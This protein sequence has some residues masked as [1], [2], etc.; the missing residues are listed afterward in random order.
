M[1][2]SPGQQWKRPPVPFVHGSSSLPQHRLTPLESGRQEV[3]P[4]G[5]S[6]GCRSHRTRRWGNTP[7]PRRCCHSRYRPRSPVGRSCSRRCTSRHSTVA[8]PD[9]SRPCR[10]YSSDHWPRRCRRNTSAR[11][12][13]PGWPL[14]QQTSWPDRPRRSTFR[15]TAFPPAH[16]LAGCRR[17]ARSGRSWPYRSGR[18]SRRASQQ[19]PVMQRPWQQSFPAPQGWAASQVGLQSL[20]RLHAT[21]VDAA[22]GHLRAAEDGIRGIRVRQRR[23]R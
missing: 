8:R 14:V 23:A 19:T 12:R 1:Q 4:R 6:I 11:C 15:C 22:V 17:T 7:R 20:P 3:R 21:V 2:E 10:W 13:Q 9:S 16:P 5:R 18:R